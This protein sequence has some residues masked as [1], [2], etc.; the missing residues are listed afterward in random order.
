[1]RKE[2][3]WPNLERMWGASLCAWF[4]A[5]K[6]H[7][8]NWSPHGACTQN[9]QSPINHVYFPTFFVFFLGSC[10][11]V[12]AHSVDGDHG[13]QPRQSPP[14][15]LSLSLLITNHHAIQ[16]ALLRPFGKRNFLKKPKVMGR[17][18]KILPIYQMFY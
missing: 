18:Q 17:I 13:G 14:L 6:Q 15:L 9:P 5:A 16:L 3:Q 4:R 12:Q 10:Q 7:N 2:L 1:M 11:K 8:L